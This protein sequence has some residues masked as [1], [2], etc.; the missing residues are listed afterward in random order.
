M[1]SGHPSTAG[2]EKVIGAV[3]IWGPASR[4]P[5][6]RLAELGTQMVK[7]CS[8]LWDQAV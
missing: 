5:R 7:L 6:G 1:L 2:W 3:A 4:L 8:K